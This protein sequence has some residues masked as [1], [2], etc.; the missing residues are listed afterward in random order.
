MRWGGA[1][2][3]ARFFYPRFATAPICRKLDHAVVFAEVKIILSL[4]GHPAIDLNDLIELL[5]SEGISAASS[6]DVANH[7]AA[8]IFSNPADTDR[9]IESLA[10]VGIHA[11]RG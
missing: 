3:L 7:Q 1:G 4:K 11:E 2:A 10:K 9:A 5:R 8:L 6:S